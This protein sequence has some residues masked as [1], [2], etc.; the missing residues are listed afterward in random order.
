MLK[1]RLKSLLKKLDLYER[2]LCIRHMY[3]IATQELILRELDYRS[4]GAPDGYPIPPPT[5]IYRIIAR[6]W[7]G[8]YWQLGEKAAD[9]LA[10]HLEKSGLDI[11]RFESVLDFGCGCGR[12]IRHLRKSTDAALHGSDINGELVDWCRRNLPFGRFEIN[13]LEPPLCYA[14]E[15]F[16]FIYQI[17]VFTHL[18]AELQLRWMEEF[19]RVLR[20]GGIMLFTTHGEPYREFLDDE[21]W[22]RLQA[23]E[24]VVI[25]ADEE[26]SNHYGSFQTCRNVEQNLLNGFELLRFSPGPERLTQDTYVVRKSAS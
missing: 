16:D 19:R 17:S 15:S 3:R 1:E 6:G 11:A 4:N 21:Q 23:G 8:E 12:L 5:L 25:E 10:S 7:A 22:R 2:A 13:G 20:P 9:D 24:V 18:G 14:E 26:G